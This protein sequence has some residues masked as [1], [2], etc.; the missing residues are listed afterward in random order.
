MWSFIKDNVFYI[1]PIN[2]ELLKL[3]IRMLLNILIIT[4]DSSVAFVILL[5]TDVKLA[6][7]TRVFEN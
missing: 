7:N 6:S 5:K 1:K 2:V 3:L 4:K